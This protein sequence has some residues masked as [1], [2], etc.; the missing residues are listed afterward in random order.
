ML[1]LNSHTSSRQQP[2]ISLILSKTC[3]RRCCPAIFE[4]HEGHLL[5]VLT[6][7]HECGT[8]YKGS[9][10]VA[11]QDLREKLHTECDDIDVG[12]Y[13]QL[14]ALEECACHDDEPVSLYLL[15]ADSQ[16]ESRV[17]H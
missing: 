5:L 17:Y 4:H 10:I 9:F 7:T 1:S 13:S 12:P 3:L 2:D 6:L 11:V 15:P 8:P 16:P 14:L